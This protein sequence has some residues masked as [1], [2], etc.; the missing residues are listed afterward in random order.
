MWLLSFLKLCFICIKFKLMEP[1]GKNVGKE[2]YTSDEGK[3]LD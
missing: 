1:F 3:D 2:N